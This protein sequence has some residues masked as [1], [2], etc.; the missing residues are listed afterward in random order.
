MEK[1]VRNTAQSGRQSDGTFGYFEKRRKRLVRSSSCDIVNPGCCARYSADMGLLKRMAARAMG[2]NY[3]RSKYNKLMDKS[4]SSRSS[5]ARTYGRFKKCASL[6]VKDTTGDAVVEATILFPIMIMIFAALVLL[7]IYL[8]TLAALQLA[9]QYTAV[10]L[11]TELS[12]TWLYFDESS[13]TLRNYDNRSQLVNV[14]A[15]LFTAG[16]DISDKGEALAAYI[17]S[18]NIS[19]KAGE[20]TVDVS[21]V[22]NLLFREIVATATR[23]FPMP[24]N[25]SFIGFPET[26]S[27][28]ATSTAVVQN[29]DEFIRNIDIASDFVDFIIEKYNLH[30]ITDA[31]SSF[32]SRV[33][34]LLG[35]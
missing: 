26:I 18:R 24:V 35:W 12:D 11:A 34:G 28:S 22:N 25:L 17:E 21:S 32:G 20:L 9:T 15:D 33:S 5:Q 2:T 4:E 7:A 29:G 31:I 6:M 10:T 30:N 3:K 14:Y 1:D 8:P 27:V 13:M 19:S 23:E 16:S